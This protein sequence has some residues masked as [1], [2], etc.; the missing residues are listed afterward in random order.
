MT[1]QYRRR[2]NRPRRRDETVLLAV[3]FLFSATEARSGEDCGYPWTIAALPTSGE[4]L[5]ISLCGI[6]CGCTPHNPQVSV[7]GSEIRVTYTQGEAPDRCTCLTI[8]YVFHDTVIVG[9]LS[10]GEYTVM[11]TT[12][13]CGIPTLVGTATVR[14]DP[15]AAVPTLDRRGAIVLA[16]LLAVAAVW[17]LST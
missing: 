8:C 3:L 10:T 16:L 2:V 11:V 14:L 12:V 6:V 9:P 5:A 1:E 4:R 13:D 15:S 7:A 17:R